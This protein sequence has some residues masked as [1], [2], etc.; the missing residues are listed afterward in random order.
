MIV[1]TVL[2]LLEGYGTP[3]QWLAILGGAVVGAFVFG[4]IGQML[5]RAMTQRRLPVLPTTI[6]RIVGG[7]LI[8]FLTALWVWHGFGFG[9]GGGPGNNNGTGTGD[10]KEEANKPP[11]PNT[12]KDKPPTP[13]APPPTP[14]AP[15]TP[16]PPPASVLRLEALTND[17]LRKLPDGDQLV[18]DHREYKVVGDDDP[19]DLR[20]LNQMLDFIQTRLDDKP[21]KPPLLRVDIET[22]SGVSPDA[23]AG[24]VT[25]LKK[26]ISDR[27]PDLPVKT[28]EH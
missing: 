10:H 28:P 27:F 19:K 9:P 1:P 12:D 24:R 16:P 22:P 8:G 13:P 2:G 15:P 25:L 20:T 18:K 7:L 14:P 5:C 23:T 17:D 11:Q 4:F 6:L 21:P 3:E 26:Q